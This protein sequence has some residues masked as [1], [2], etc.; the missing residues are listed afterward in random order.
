MIVYPHLN[1]AFQELNKFV[2]EIPGD[3]DNPIIT[4]YIQDCGLLQCPIHE[5]IPWCSAFVAHCLRKSKT[6]FLNTLRARDWLKYG[7]SLEHPVYGC[8]I[9]L[10]RNSIDSTT[11][12]VG[13]FMG[14][15]SDNKHVYIL[16][17]NQKNAVNIS[18]YNIS[19]ILGYRNVL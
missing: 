11:G 6:R 12:H 18:H 17:G 1:I 5:E 7:T 19:R 3:E 9:I 14:F 4:K 15:S 13:F 2:S 16:G 8:I 10:W